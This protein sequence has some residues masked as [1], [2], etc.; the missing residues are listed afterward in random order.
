MRVDA[1]LAGFKRAAERLLDAERPDLLHFH[2]FGLTEASLARLAR[3]RGI[4]YAFTYHSP[5][6]SCRREDLLRWGTEPCDGE[7]QTLRCS[8][9]KLHQRVGGHPWLSYVLASASTPAAG[10]FH[11]DSNVNRRRRVAFVTDTKRFGAR[12][13]EFLGSCSLAVA[14][15]EWSIPVLTRNGASPA[16]VKLCPQ[17]VPRDFACTIQAAAETTSAGNKGEFVVGYVGRYTL[18]KGVQI[19]AEAFQSLDA[20]NARL[21]IYGW[22]EHDTRPLDNQI[23]ELARLDARIEVRPRLSFEEM[24]VE[25]RQIDLLAV[26]SVWFETGPLVVLEALQLGIPV[27][28]SN[29]IGQ[30]KLLRERGRVVEPNTPGAWRRALG[31]AYGLFQAGNWG[32]E[33][34]R[35]FGDGRLR[36]MSDVAE[37]LLCDYRQL[38]RDR[39]RRDAT[40]PKR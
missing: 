14:C 31:E 36:N 19:L 21:R 7:V 33:R 29:R 25:Y 20:P 16:V 8:A 38:V 39:P 24:L 1:P 34:Q 2:T 5:A 9:C 10:L 15:S 3:E 4:P 12:L 26:P 11:K 40:A 18:V 37:E 13:R 17:G 22:T 6:W 28:G 30:L 27:Y 35:A 23:R 32:R